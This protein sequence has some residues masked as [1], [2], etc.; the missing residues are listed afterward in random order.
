[1]TIY[2]LGDL[3]P[4]IHP[5]AY[6]H[7]DAV[8][9][10]RVRIGAQSSVWP[11]VVLRGDAGEIRVGERTS[12]QDG[13]IVHATAHEP[14]VI[15]SDCVVGHNAHLEGCVI[16]EGS[17]IGSMSV[18]L[19]GVEVG[20]G[21]LV[22]AGA[23]VRPGTVIPPRAMAAGVPARIREEAVEAGAFLGAAQSYVA[24]GIRYASELRRLD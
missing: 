21:A 17:L 3:V 10:G 11:G 13:T 12:V 20:A 23:V 6:V 24:N 1:M 18:V 8:V 14:T 4:D 5:D 16:G 19:N 15:G 2:A 22:A 7:P 9:I